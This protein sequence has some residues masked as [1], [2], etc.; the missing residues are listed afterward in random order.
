MSECT[1]LQGVV[2]D[3]IAM[4]YIVDNGIHVNDFNLFL[5]FFLTKIYSPEKK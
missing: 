4:C 3:L 5:F 2:R 1:E